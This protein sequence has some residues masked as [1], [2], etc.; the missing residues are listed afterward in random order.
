MPACSQSTFCTMVAAEYTSRVEFTACGIHFRNRGHSMRHAPN[1]TGHIMHP[2][3]PHTSSLAR[4]DPM[5]AW[6][7]CWPSPGRR[8][9][10][11]LLVR[12]CLGSRQSQH[13]A[14]VCVASPS[15]GTPPPPQRVGVTNH[16]CGPEGLL[17][18]DCMQQPHDTEA[19][20]FAMHELVQPGQL[21][22]QAVFCLWLCLHPNMHICTD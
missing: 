11:V 8:V 19:S 17:A 7:G 12:R 4:R 3:L 21:A 22:A 14:G 2:K 10:A 1:A 18:S 20:T 9:L 6:S 5:L 16:R 15:R 13:L